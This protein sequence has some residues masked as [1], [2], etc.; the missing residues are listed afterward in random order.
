MSLLAHFKQAASDP[1]VLKTKGSF[2]RA[3]QALL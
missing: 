2:I 3:V 1:S